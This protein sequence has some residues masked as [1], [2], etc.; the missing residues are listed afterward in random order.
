MQTILV[1]ITFT[2]AVAFILKKFVWSPI[3][4]GDQL[5]EALVREFCAWIVDS[6]LDDVVVAAFNQNVGDGVAQNLSFR[7]R[8]HMALAF[9]ARVFDQHIVVQPL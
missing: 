5:C 6:A 7:N 9:A 3:V 8:Q 2:I 4:E 1:L